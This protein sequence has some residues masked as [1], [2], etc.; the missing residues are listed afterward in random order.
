MDESA[1]QAP[2]LPN[3]A[4]PV[5]KSLKVAGYE[6]FPGANGCGIDR[7]ILPGV[8]VIAG[9]NGLGKTTLLNVM[10]RLLVGPLNPQKVNPFEVGAKSHE[11]VGWKHARR[12]FR[13]RVSDAAIE[14]TARADITI[15]SHVLTVER[16]LKD[17]SITYLAYDSAEL[18]PTEEEYKRVVLEATNVADRYDFDFLVRYLVFFLEQRVPLFWNERGQIEAFR[19]LLCEAQLANDF[20]EKEDEI[21]AKDSVYRN[22]RWHINNLKKRLLKERSALA[23]SS[24]QAAKLAALNEEMA[25]LRVRD[26]SLV[27]AITSLAN[28]RSSL[29]SSILIRKIELEEATRAAEGLQQ[30]FL[31]SLFPQMSDSARHVFSS[32]LSSRGCTVCGNKSNR[33]LLRLERLLEQGICPA[34]E[35]PPEEQEQ[36]SHHES[37]PHAELEVVAATVARLSKSIAGEEARERELD[38]QLRQLFLEERTAKQDMAARL[39]AIQHVTAQLP[40]TPEELKSLE[41]QIEDGDAELEV[42]LAELTRLYAEYEDLLAAITTR[43]TQVGERVK[44]KFAHFAKA[45]LSESCS[46]GQKTYTETLGESRT[47]TYPCFNVYMTSAVSPEEQTERQLTDDV[48]ESQREFIDLAFRMALIAAVTDEGARSMLVIETPEASL[49]SYFVT[50]AGQM[51]RE[52]AAGDSAEGNVVIVSSNLASQN[53]IPALLG[54]DENVAEAEWPDAEE[55]KARVIN[56]L[57]EGAKNA[58]L[59]ERRRYYEEFLER[60]TKG[61]ISHASR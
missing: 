37:L 47:F 50:Q 33:G 17:L 28:E 51:L 43:V 34:C 40:A 29:R 7:P 32:L 9:I 2:A 52:F 16:A 15:G 53:M 48:S 3:I 6:L 22:L 4:L 25:A 60:A 54:L 12:F 46:L 21:R 23:G 10:L 44:E 8:T 49:D 39:S 61:R 20:R 11:L 58:A 31:Q 36:H 24:S 13:A 41:V 57:A 55:V 18:E 59:R 38:A 45:F 42:K 19:I 27:K 35:S 5:F 14:A 26:A 1:A 30:G 56:L